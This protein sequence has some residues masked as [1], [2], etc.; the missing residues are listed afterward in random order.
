MTEFPRFKLDKLNNDE[1]KAIIELKELLK[2][3]HMAFLK[4]NCNS[5]HE[6]NFLKVLRDGALA[7][8]GHTITDCSRLLL[9]K[10]DIEPFLNECTDIFKSYMKQALEYK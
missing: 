10:S 8:C 6:T 4:L 3:T 5:F 9:N 7:Y 1:E 2:E